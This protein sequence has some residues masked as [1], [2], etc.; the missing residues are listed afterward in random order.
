M[1]LKFSHFLFEK[2]TGCPI[3]T[4]DL[5][6]NLENRQTAIDKYG[7]GPA[8]PDDTVADNT[9]FWQKKAEMWKCSVDNLKTMKCGNCAAFNISSQM[10]ACIEGGL[11]EGADMGVIQKADLGYCE[12]LHFKCAGD[13]TCD[14]WLVNGPLD[15]KDIK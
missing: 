1:V 13:R 10:R 9:M 11:K 12:L 7:Y 2:E 15:N 6:K 14:A 8:N 5:V 3:E 4:H